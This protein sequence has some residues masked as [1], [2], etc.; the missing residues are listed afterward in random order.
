MA[1]TSDGEPIGT[2]GGGAA[3]ARA[4]RLAQAQEP[5]NALVQLE[6]TDAGDI[7]MVCGGS[8]EILINKFDL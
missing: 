7:G 3:E 5:G 6:L 1:L 8:V 4:I 2:I